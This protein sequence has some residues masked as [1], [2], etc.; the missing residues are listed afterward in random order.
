LRFACLEPFRRWKVSYDGVAVRTPYDEMLSGRVRDGFKEIVAYELEV[1]CVAPAWDPDSGRHGG[2][3]HGGMSEQVWASVHYEQLLRATGTITLG[4]RVVEFDGTG[5]RDHSLGVR[6]KGM[7]QFGGH[8]LVQVP[9]AEDRG[10]GLLRLWTPDGTITLDTAYVL[11][12]GVLHHAEIIEA[13]RLGEIVLAGEQLTLLLRSELGEHRLHG[14]MLRTM[15]LTIAP[16]WGM[17]FGADPAHGLGV[18]A[19]GFARWTWDGHIGHGLTER[20][21]QL[22][23]R[24]PELHR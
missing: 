24:A 22:P 11:I 3:G 19:P 12:D 7:D 1:E 10:V 14:E 21:E 5:V 17:P 6:G 9:F 16:S 2:A 23:V 20:S 15:Y 8:L 4:D 18:F 13:P